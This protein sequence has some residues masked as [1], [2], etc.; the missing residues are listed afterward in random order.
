MDSSQINT[1]MNSLSSGK[2]SGAK[3]RRELFE[4]QLR[5]LQK[6]ISNLSSK[7]SVPSIVTANRFQNRSNS[8]F[9]D[10]SSPNTS[11]LLDT[12]LSSAATPTYTQHKVSNRHPN[13]DFVVE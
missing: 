8:S 9:V 12:S 10:Q 2:P 5:D 6:D 1:S 11:R 3:S 4:E 7:L 13:N